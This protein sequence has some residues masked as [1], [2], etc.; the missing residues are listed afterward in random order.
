MA[1]R[2]NRM[3][4]RKPEQKDV[5]KSLVKMVVIDELPF[6]IVEQ[7]GFKNFMQAL[8]PPSIQ[9]PSPEMISKGCAKL[10]EDEKLNDADGEEIGNAVETCLHDWEI[11]NILTISTG[12]ASSNDAA[13]NYLKT[14]LVNNVLDGKF[15]HLRCIVDFINDLVKDGLN[16]Y[17]ES[18]AR[19][20]EAVA[21]VRDSP[22]RVKLIKQC[23]REYWKKFNKI[24]G[25]FRDHA[26]E[27]WL[28][29]KSFVCLDDP[30]NWT[31]TYEMIVA[32]KLFKEAFELYERKD[33]SYRCD[34]EDICGVPE[35][36]DWENVMKVENFLKGFHRTSENISELYL[37]ANKFLVEI[38]DIDLHLDNWGRCAHGEKLFTMALDM[39]LKF[40]QCW[41]NVENSNM[42]IYVASILDPRHKLG[43]IE[44]YFMNIFKH[45]Y[46]DEG[47]KMWKH[48]MR[49]V[50][51]STYD[52]FDDYRSK[53]GGSQQ[54][55]NIQSRV[56]M[57]KYLSEDESQVR[58]RVGTGESHD[59]PLRTGSGPGQPMYYGPRYVND[60]GYPPGIVLQDAEEMKQP[61]P[62]A[63]LGRAPQ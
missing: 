38:D 56:F 36:G 19:V 3:N 40:D 29:S 14:R 42:L 4:T 51:T 31:S 1:A 45:D 13:I 47:E 49:M 33:P 35:Y 44:N 2:G 59:M 55:A 57:E 58:R 41:G 9:L 16:L 46:T 26:R 15:L 60:P 21:Y 62:D 20:R 54:N 27:Y 12:I 8:C 23:L 24:S 28:K 37:T 61:G 7:S 53:I 48:K 50:L 34:M 18:I 11:S 5:L 6:S 43:H 30:T 32:A 17:P 39:K 10:F 25:G 63:K 22:D 52:V